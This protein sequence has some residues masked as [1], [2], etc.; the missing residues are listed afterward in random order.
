MQ[1]CVTVAVLTAF[2]PP[3]LSASR[4]FARGNLRLILLLLLR[5][6]VDDS[7]HEAQN[8]ERC[9]LIPAGLESAVGAHEDVLVAQFEMEAAAVAKGAARV[10]F[11]AQQHGL[12]RHLA[13]GPQLLPEASV[14]SWSLNECVHGTLGRTMDAVE[15]FR[16]STTSAGTDRY[17]TALKTSL[18]VQVPYV[19]TLARTRGKP[20]QIASTLGPCGGR[21]GGA[22]GAS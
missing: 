15:N 4:H 2:T 10:H 12:A 5:Y 19:V 9:V 1:A 6:T 17:A 3:S 22:F 13:I 18:E 21:G 20:P 11:R 7:E 16:S 14:F 8:V